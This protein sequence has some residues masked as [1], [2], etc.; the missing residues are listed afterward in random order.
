MWKSKKITFAVFIAFTM[1]ASAFANGGIR[2]YWNATGTP[3]AE[4]TLKNDADISLK[5]ENLTLRFVDDSVIVDCDYIL[6]NKSGSDKQIE[7]AFNITDA[8]NDSLI[9][10]SIYLNGEKIPS[11][12]HKE[13]SWD[14][15]ESVYKFWELSKLTL[16]SKKE[17]KVSVT[18]RVQTSND[19]MHYA[20]KFNDNSFIY[21]LYPALSFGNGII[22][23]FNITVDVSDILSW[24][25]KIKKIEGVDL[26]FKDS[27]MI[28]S[29][30]YSNFDLNKHRQLKIT[31]N[32]K[33]WYFRSLYEQYAKYPV[34]NADSELTEGKTIY[35]AANMSDHNCDTAWV[36]GKSDFGKGQ[37][38]KINIKGWITQVLL[39]NGFRK[40]EKTFYENN[41]IKRIAL[42]VDGVR[43]GEMEFPD[44]KYC[45][46]DMTNILDEGELL[47]LGDFFGENN[48]SKVL[49][50]GRG[51]ISDSNIEIEILDV[52]RG[53]KYN[54]TCVSDIY[55]IA[56][57]IPIP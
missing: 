39:V 34:I 3:P 1:A 33:N 10:Y 23:D 51:F 42:Y 35:A 38:I 6:F 37:K 9:Y 5:K 26:G 28:I 56:A 48:L 16:A 32:I 41:R 7:F 47:N 22:E 17:S 11:N 29:K 45:R 20:N 46:V 18:Y 13:T 21:N 24:G 8:S 19:G 44:R 55:V 27:D 14:E 53:T 12:F 25:G 31:Y 43:L 52:Y 2:W 49:Q 15:I 4:I 30:H 54:D 36:E 50:S 57:Q 40:T